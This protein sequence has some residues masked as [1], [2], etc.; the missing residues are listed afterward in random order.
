MLGSKFKLFLNN[1]FE[2]SISS[3]QLFYI[4]SYALKNKRTM[5]QSKKVSKAFN[6]LISGSSKNSAVQRTEMSN[7]FQTT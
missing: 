2:N 5:T 4:F 7:L 3:F 6:K 1:N